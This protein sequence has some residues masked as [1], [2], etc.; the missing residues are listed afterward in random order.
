MKEKQRKKRVRLSPNPP[1]QHHAAAA[2][3]QRA[4]ESGSLIS[5]AQET[6]EVWMIKMEYCVCSPMAN[7]SIRGGGKRMANP[8]SEALIGP[9]INS[10]I[11]GKEDSSPTGSEPYHPYQSLQFQKQYFLHSLITLAANYAK[12]HD[13]FA[14]EI[15]IIAERT[16]N[17]R[18]HNSEAALIHPKFKMQICKEAAS[19]FEEQT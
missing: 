9:L 10:G 14:F 6:A 8:L 1:K 7:K 17:D 18:P 3:R 19:T 12:H 4:A 16:R 11:L 15:N 13:R 2:E 5:A